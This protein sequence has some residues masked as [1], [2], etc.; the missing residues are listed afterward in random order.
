[1]LWSSARSRRQTAP[2]TRYFKPELMRLEEREVLNATMDVPTFQ[3]FLP[4]L[5]STIVSFENSLQSVLANLTSQLTNLNQ[6][7]SHLQVENNYL[8]QTIQQLEHQLQYPNPTPPSTPPSAPSLASFAGVYRAAQVPDSVQGDIPAG[9]QQRIY[10]T[11]HSDGSG[12]LFIA[13]F[14]GT[15]LTLSFN[16]GSITYT[17]GTIGFTYPGLPSH[18][19]FAFTPASGNQLTGSLQGSGNWGQGGSS[20]GFSF[21]NL[22]FIKES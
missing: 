5:T 4:A 19:E 20:V 22:D 12:Q 15:N 11:L 2:R 17:N 6:E 3:A 10:F 21:S 14:D 8:M 16:A 13:P 7:L 18:L 1:M 9:T